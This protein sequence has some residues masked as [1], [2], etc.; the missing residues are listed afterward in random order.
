MLDRNRWYQND[1]M[2][3]VYLYLDVDELIWKKGAL[4]IV[5]YGS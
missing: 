1:I 5:E 2:K 3:A 4:R